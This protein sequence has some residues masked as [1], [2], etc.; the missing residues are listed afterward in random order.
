MF[1]KIY[2]EITSSLHLAIKKHNIHDLLLFI[3]VKSKI[4]VK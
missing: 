4:I 2:N 3:I 1:L